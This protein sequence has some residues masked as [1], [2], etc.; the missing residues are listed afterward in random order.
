MHFTTL[1]T[2]VI[3]ALA[4]TS[5]AAPLVKSILS[6]VEVSIEGFSSMPQQRRQGLVGGLTDT[7]TGVVDGAVGTVGNVV[8][9]VVP[10]GAGDGVSD[11]VGGVVKAV[12]DTVDGTVGLRRQLEQVDGVVDGVVGTAE[13]A[14]DGAAGAVSNVAGGI[15]KARQEQTGNSTTEGSTEQSSGGILGGVLG[16]GDGEGAGVLLEASTCFFSLF[17]NS[18]SVSGV[19]DTVGQVVDDATGL[20]LGE[21]LSGVVDTAGNVVGGVADTAGGVVDSTGLKKMR[22]MPAPQDDS[23]CQE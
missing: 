14:V 19:V 12:G 22:R 1:Y 15:L 9:G 23:E 16:S 17:L 4:S 11:T 13:K 8:D 21:V 5:I 10:L 18:M 20:G 6:L 2:L 7:V 3:A